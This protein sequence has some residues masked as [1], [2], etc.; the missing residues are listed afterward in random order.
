MRRSLALFLLASILLSPIPFCGWI[1]QWI[2]PTVTEVPETEVAEFGDAP[3]PG[4]PSLL[5]SNGLR[6]LDPS[7]FWL[8]GFDAP[9]ATLEG[10]AK[11]TDMDEQD[12]GLLELLE[13]KP[14]KVSLTFQAAKSEQAQAGVVYFNL[15]AD[16]NN[17]GRWQD[18]VGLSDT[19]IKE[20]VVENQAISLAPGKTA[21]IEAEFPQV[22]GALEH[23]IR[24]ALTD[25]PISAVEPYVT[26]QYQMGEVEDY[27]ILPPYA[28]GIEC[29]PDQYEPRDPHRLVILHGTGGSFD[30]ADPTFT[31]EK[32][33]VRSV[34]GSGEDPEAKDIV[35][36]PGLKAGLGD[37]ADPAL[38]VESTRTHSLA[39]GRVSVDYTIDLT[40]EG[41]LGVKTLTCEVTVNHPG[42]VINAAG[43][44]TIIV[45]G[46]LQVATGEPFVV[47]IQVF[48]RN[49]NPAPEGSVFSASFGDP[50][51]DQ[52]A[53][54][55]SGK[56]DAEGRIT[57]TLGVNWPAGNI[58]ILYLSL[59]GGT[60]KG[61]VISVID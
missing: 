3:D 15:W 7:S 50:P 26:G 49:G 30:I 34:K 11:T 57:L 53:T 61:P 56:L 33:E 2:Q 44:Y 60:V 19:P 52:K 1:Q 55:A 48:D 39:G 9:G 28:W 22:A 45:V 32:L 41:P 27:H 43:G 5:A 16:T 25:T 18:S 13:H 58:E 24:A 23:W 42:V 47:T 40:V 46:P 12:D 36:V 51:S 21:Q 54:H 4:F 10:D 6:T 31:A 35:V 37:I 8:G 38:H 59:F 29:D 20:W 17:D 14:G